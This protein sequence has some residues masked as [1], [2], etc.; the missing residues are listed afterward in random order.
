MNLM[1]KLNFGTLN[2]FRKNILTNTIYKSFSQQYEGIKGDVNW[3]DGEIL[4][5]RPSLKRHIPNLP[6]RRY[7]QV[8]LISSDFSQELKELNN[9]VYLAYSRKKRGAGK[10]ED[11]VLED[12]NK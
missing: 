4:D 6:K 11:L 9:P 3:A 7:G 10:R 8:R 12:K 5:G 2:M 1:H